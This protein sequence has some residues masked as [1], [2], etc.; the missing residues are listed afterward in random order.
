MNDLH[1]AWRI[2]ILSGAVA[3][4]GVGL[5]FWIR[6][7]SEVSRSVMEK[8]EKR[9]WFLVVLLLRFIGVIMW[10]HHKRKLVASRD[11]LAVPADNPP[12]PE[13]SL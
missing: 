9:N 10:E 1:I 7:L 8:A 2:L 6:A 5:Y 13:E 3:G 11:P 4:I 12:P